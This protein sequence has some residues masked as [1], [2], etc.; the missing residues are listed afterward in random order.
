MMTQ[1]EMNNEGAR[2]NLPLK[3]GEVP[4]DVVALL[5]ERAAKGIRTIGPGMIAGMMKGLIDRPNVTFRTETPARRLVGDDQGRVVGV[6]A[7]HG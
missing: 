3:D 5:E 2:R 7:E 1:D 6:V 4:L